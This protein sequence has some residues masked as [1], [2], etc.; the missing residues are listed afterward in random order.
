ASAGV[1][2]LE[3]ITLSAS[4]LDG[5]IQDVLNYAKILRSQVPVEPVDLDSLVRDIIY[6]YPEWQQPEGLVAIDG[7]LPTVHG[8][9]AWL[10]QCFSNLLSNAVKFVAHGVQ[11]RV[12]IWAEP[13]PTDGSVPLPPA[14]NQE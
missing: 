6:S 1:S 3:R 10:T 2:Y 13:A 4:R 12:R 5:L 9:Q 14:A 7:S 8:N 11:P